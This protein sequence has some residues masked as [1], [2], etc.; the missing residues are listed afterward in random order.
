MAIGDGITGVIDNWAEVSK[1]TDATG[2]LVA[3][4]DSVPD[5]INDDTYSVND[6]VSNIN[7]DEDDHDLAQIEILSGTL[8][9]TGA[10]SNA[11]AASALL[12]IALSAVLA[13]W[14]RTRQTA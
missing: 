11:L 4:V 6:D 8:A 1:F 9:F 10:G 5:S 3:D 7:G 13:H 14:S 2:T 12:L